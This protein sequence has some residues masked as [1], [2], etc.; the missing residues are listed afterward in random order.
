MNMNAFADS[1][2]VFK[3]NPENQRVR[4]RFVEFID[5]W[6]CFGA[7][8]DIADLVVSED[9]RLSDEQPV[10]ILLGEVVFDVLDL[11]LFLTEQSRILR[12]KLE[13]LITIN[14]QQPQFLIKIEFEKCFVLV[15]DHF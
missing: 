8:T 4:I 7:K 3:G 9:L 14:F 10:E 12:V 1:I 11:E 13:H 2:L 6:G 5:S 15:T